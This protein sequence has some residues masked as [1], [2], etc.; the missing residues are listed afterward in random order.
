MGLPFAV[1]VWSS[2]FWGPGEGP[3]GI[4]GWRAVEPYAR[5]ADGWTLEQVRAEIATEWERLK[6]EYPEANEGWRI[7]IETVKDQVTADDYDAQS[8]RV[9]F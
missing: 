3:R 8:G 6:A 4:R 1:D 7:G 5:I 2:L 9:A